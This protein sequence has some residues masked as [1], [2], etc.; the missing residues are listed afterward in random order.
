MI[1]LKLTRLK[2]IPQA[3]FFFLLS[4]ERSQIPVALF[5]RHEFVLQF[6]DLEHQ[7]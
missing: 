1:V 7:P 3:D 6:S 4:L 2:S 5:L